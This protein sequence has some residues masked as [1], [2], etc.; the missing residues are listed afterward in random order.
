MTFEPTTKNRGMDKIKN[1]VQASID[2]KQMVLEDEA[3]LQTVSDCVRLIVSAFKNGN[4][5]FYYL[6]Y[7]HLSAML[8]EA[9][10]YADHIKRNLPDHPYHT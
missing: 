1:I 4:K 9:E 10:Y 3:L 2:V 7:K 8:K 5:V 6:Q